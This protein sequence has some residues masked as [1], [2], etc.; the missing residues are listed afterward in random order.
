[1]IEDLLS[2]CY[3][4]EGITTQQDPPL[5]KEHPTNPLLNK[6]YYIHRPEQAKTMETEVEKSEVR[7][8][9]SDIQVSKMNLALGNKDPEI[10]L[11]PFAECQG[12][13]KVPVATVFQD[14]EF[15]GARD[16]A[17]LAVHEGKNAQRDLVRKLLKGSKWP[18]LYEV[19]IPVLHQKTHQVL[20]ESINMLLPHEILA[21]TMSWNTLSKH[22]V[23]DRV[24]LSASAR[25][26]FEKTVP[27]LGMDPNT[28][29][30]LGLWTDGC[31]A[32]WD[33]SQSVIVIT[34]SFCGQRDDIFSRLRIP[35]CAF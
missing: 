5:K 13:W 19:K 6:Y 16:V 28:C 26:H 23:F 25:K 33:R 7:V 22:K 24:G 31:P 1:M 8:D 11:E 35:L 4:R 14:A 3:Q 34:M 12:S 29:I 20:E 32:K 15:D 17:D 30:P 27:L 18:P 21:N 9:A 2:D 10:K